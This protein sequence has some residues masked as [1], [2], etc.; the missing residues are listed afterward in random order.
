MRVRSNP[1]RQLYILRYEILIHILKYKGD[2]MIRMTCNNTTI[3]LFKDKLVVSRFI[4]AK[5]IVHVEILNP[6]TT[7][8]EFQRL[9]QLYCYELNDIQFKRLA[10]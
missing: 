10:E 8:A 9:I 5:L 4:K 6:T 1:R 3:E 7:V 2:E